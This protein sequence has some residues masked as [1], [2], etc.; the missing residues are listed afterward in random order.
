MTETTVWDETFT[1]VYQ[2]VVGADA[3]NG[4]TK[5]EAFT[6][7]THR[8]LA[9]IA[10]GELTVDVS[11][12]VRATLARIDDTQGRA[13]DHVIKRLSSGQQDLNL[14]TDPS[15]NTVVKLGDGKRKLWRYV[16][17]EDLIHMDRLRYR[18]YRAQRLAYNEW[19]ESLHAILP[20]V[21]R[22]PNLGDAVADG[23]FR[24]E[25]AA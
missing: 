23:A 5:Q 19:Q 4:T 2:E 15:L 17:Q 20:V 12:A 1:R 13:A 3:V 16:T 6:V 11:E 24:H 14:D 7:A 22:Y 25:V 8:I 18:N 9:M 10:A 21:T